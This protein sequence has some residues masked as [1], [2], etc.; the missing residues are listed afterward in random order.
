MVRTIP[1]TFS[2]MNGENVLHKKDYKLIHRRHRIT[3]HFILTCENSR[4]FLRIFIIVYVVDKIIN[5][6]IIDTLLKNTK[7]TVIKN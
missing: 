6:I 3:Y 4:A 1:L 7:L 5:S 2:E